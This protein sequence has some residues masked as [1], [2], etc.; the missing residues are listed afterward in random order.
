MQSFFST[1]LGYFNIGRDYVW[2]LQ[3]FSIVFLTLLISF[4]CNRLLKRLLVKLRKTKTAWDDAMVIAIRRPVRALIWLMGF[5]LAVNVIH[6]KIAADNTL[7]GVI[8]PARDIAIICI[9]SWFLINLI[10]EIEKNILASGSTRIDSTTSDAISKLLKAAVMITSGLIAMQTLGFS[11]TGV[12]AFGGVGGVAIGFAAKDMLANFFGALMIYLGRPFKVGDWIRSPDKSIEGTVEHIGW[13]Q[14]HIRTFDK[15]PLYVPNA[16]FSTIIVE[17]ASR[18]SHRRIYE[19]VGIRY[20]DMAKATKITDTVK[21]MLSIHEDIDQ[22][23]TLMVNV[24]RFGPS[25]VDFFIYAF[26][27]TKDWIEF[28]RVKHDIL[29]KIAAIIEKHGAEIAFPTQTLHI[30]DMIEAG[31]SHSKKK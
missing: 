19:Y 17:N 9:I 8:Y 4:F 18:M 7:F 27:R 30:P 14:T 23:Q 5:M 6:H 16:V 28:Q 12:L 31:T 11:I 26:T 10:N 25:S 22:K 3:V 20:D 13:R 15:R 2:V 21:E 29:L 1:L 24:D